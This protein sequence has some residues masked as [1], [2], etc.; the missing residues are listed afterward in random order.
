MKLKLLIAAI[1]F[2]AIIAQAHAQSS[3][4]LERT[5]VSSAALEARTAL[6]NAQGIIAEMEKAGFNTTRVEDIFTVLLEFYSGQVALE[7]NGTQSYTDIIKRADEITKVRNEAFDAKQRLRGLELRMQNTNI[8]KAEPMKLYFAAEQ[9]IQ[10]ERYEEAKIKIEQAYAKVA[11][12]E[13][14]QSTGRV[15]ADITKSTGQ[16]LL[17]LW[18]EV[19]IAAAIISAAVF[20]SYNKIAIYLLQRKM[21][22]LEAEKKTLESLIKE[23][24][25]HY[26]HSGKMAETTYHININKFGEMIRDIERQLPLLRE[27][28][29]GQRGA[30]WKRI[31]KERAKPAPAATKIALPKFPSIARIIEKIMAKR[32]ELPAK[33]RLRL[34]IGKLLKAEKPELKPI[35]PLQ[36]PQPPAKPKPTAKTKLEF[37]KIELP[38]IKA[39]EFRLPKVQLPKMELPKIKAPQIQL[40][41]LKVPKIALPKIR[42]RLPAIPKLPERKIEKKAE[43]K[44][45]PPKLKLPKFSVPKIK[46]EPPKLPQVKIKPPRLKPPKLSLP[47]IELP[48]FRVPKFKT[49]KI[50]LPQFKAPAIKLPH[51]KREEKKL[52][53][54]K[55]E[56]PQKKKPVEKSKY[57]ALTELAEKLKEGEQKITSQ[58]TFVLKKPKGK[59]L[60]KTYGFNLS[61]YFR[62]NKIRKSLEF[63]S[64]RNKVS[65]ASRNKFRDEPK[66]K[67]KFEM[68]RLKAPKLPAFKKP[69][70][71]S[72]G[73]LKEGFE[74]IKK[75]AA[76]KLARIKRKARKIGK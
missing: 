23:T 53:L 32:P 50:E 70:P 36:K 49:P 72:L 22:S 7:A 55:P 12:L 29:E 56:V 46:L 54:E 58:K 8:D 69:K 18:K 63:K 73:P 41:K 13:A 57:I 42:I 31:K 10:S 66:L 16:R 34:E 2:L 40:P 65:R 62:A 71:L 27:Q 64:T 1:F 9:D 15:I 48:K 11:D 61:R 6:L 21:R 20:L 76:E 39:P 52:I 47:K 59:A 3:E 24:Q 60:E 74:S 43:A 68:P 14:R 37:P 26:F 45:E 67:A 4:I 35:P 19:L 25:E 17:E 33:T 38:K 30:I 51:L 75:T 44:I 5:N 28:I